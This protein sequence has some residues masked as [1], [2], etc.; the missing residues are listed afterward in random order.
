MKSDVASDECSVVDTINITMDEVNK[1]LYT[2]TDSIIVTIVLPVILCL[3]VVFNS[4]FLFVVFLFLF[5][6]ATRLR[7][8]YSFVVFVGYFTPMTLTT[9]MTFERY[10]ALCHPLKHLKIRGRPR[11]LK[12]VTCCWLVGT[13]CAILIVPSSAVLQP[14]CLRWSDDGSPSELTTVLITSCSPV[15][16]WVI[17]F[18]GPLTS[19]P[20][21][22]VMIGNIYMYTRIIIM[23]NKR[24]S[25]GG[26]LN[27]DKRALQIRNQVAK[28]LIVNGVVFFICQTPYV[29]VVFMY[30]FCVV[31]GIP[32]SLQTLFDSTEVWILLIP[33][34]V[35]TI[36]NPFI[37]GVM[38]AQYRAAFLQAFG[39]KASPNGQSS[40]SAQQMRAVSATL[41]T[42][43][44]DSDT[45]D[46]N[47]TIESRG[48]RL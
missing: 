15:Y 31:L 4:T 17:Y 26:I 30:W 41:G 11:T 22:A 35:N 2:P 16:P 25:S 45:A 7:H 34:L 19:I 48:T 47:T 38:N 6:L 33:T 28:M 14:S 36:V 40:R 44:R 42:A 3:G 20:Y 24:G 12:I 32:T 9:M 29:V 1:L 43:T 13:A 39:C 18:D 10:L 23:L 8:V 37:Y 27:K 21:L 46:P 5:N